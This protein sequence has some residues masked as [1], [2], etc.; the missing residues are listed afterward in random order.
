[1]SGHG[2]KA[3]LVLDELRQ[4]WRDLNTDGQLGDKLA[5]METKC[6]QLEEKLSD[7]R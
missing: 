5:A 4:R 7:A 2:E 1:M 3:L 6:E